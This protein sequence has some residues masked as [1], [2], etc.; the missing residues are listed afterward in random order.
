MSNIFAKLQDSFKKASDLFVS[1]TDKNGDTNCDLTNVLFAICLNGSYPQD[2]VLATLDNLVY[3]DQVNHDFYVT[4]S[5]ESIIT[6]FGG[7]QN[8]LLTGKF[9]K[10]YK[11]LAIRCGALEK[12]IIFKNKILFG[13]GLNFEIKNYFK[14]YYF[15]DLASENWWRDLRNVGKK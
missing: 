6:K 7:L 5:N 1:I 10:N 14:N 8:T 12:Q 11:Q 15:C 2:S 4:S 3:K 9:D 13:I